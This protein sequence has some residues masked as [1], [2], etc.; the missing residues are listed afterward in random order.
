MTNLPVLWSAAYGSNRSPSVRSLARRLL[1][2]RAF[3]R[4]LALADHHWSGGY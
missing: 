1:R 4:E 2:V 3:L